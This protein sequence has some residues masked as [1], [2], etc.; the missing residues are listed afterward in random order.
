MGVGVE[1][2]DEGQLSLEG[3]IVQGMLKQQKKFKEDTKEGKF[4]L[5]FNPHVEDF[6]ELGELDQYLGKKEREQVGEIL[7]PSNTMAIK[8]HK[9]RREPSGTS[10]LDEDEIENDERIENLLK[11]KKRSDL[12][13]RYPVEGY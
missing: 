3:G 2:N 12:R 11:R 6:L 9:M 13:E 1:H 8:A 7:S 10:L 4:P 5:W